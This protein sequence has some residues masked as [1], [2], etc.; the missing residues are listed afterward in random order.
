M[1]LV[2]LDR[3]GRETAFALEPG[4]LVLPRLSPTGDRVALTVTSD[5][6][7]QI[8][9]Y[10]IGNKTLVP[11]T[12]VGSNYRSSWSPDG[13]RVAF[14]SDREDG[15][16]GIYWMPADGSGPAEL[17]APNDTTGGTTSWTRDGNWIVFDGSFD[18][19]KSDE[20]IYAI[21]TGSDRARR[22]VVSTGGTDESG[23]VSP[24][25]RWIAYVSDEAG[26]SQ[27]YVRPFLQPGGRWLVSSGF[28]VSPLWASDTELLYIDGSS[29]QRL[30]SARLAFD[31]DP[32]VLDR[33]PLFDWTPYLPGTRSY[34]PY[35]LTRD[36][37][38]IVTTRMLTGESS[39][40]APV[41]VLDWFA[42]VRQ[43]VAEQGGTAR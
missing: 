25:G 18:P 20:D 14:V 16:S 4:R 29:T 17:I 32:R 19:G 40:S 43:R 31:P 28:G 27:V 42:E 30:V 22:T 36:G 9:I 13:R 37:Q 12:S 5:K 38:R 41:V 3:S 6:G 35:D 33:T 21:G 10:S 15:S 24:D 23:T 11:L 1:Q 2:E 7:Y 26:Q 39:R 8:W 34:P